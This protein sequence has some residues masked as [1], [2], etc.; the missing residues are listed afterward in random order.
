MAKLRTVIWYTIVLIVFFALYHV[1]S[2]Y[3]IVIVDDGFTY[4]VPTIK[5]RSTHIIDRRRSRVLA[6]ERDALVVFKVIDAGKVK[7]MFG[8][9][10]AVPGMTVLVEGGRVLVDRKDVGPAPKGLDVVATG[11]IV[12]RD[13][14]FMGFDSVR[15]PKLPLAARLI[16]YRDIIGLVTNP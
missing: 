14:V 16:P 13:T 10:V 7:R 1:G 8:R 2:T 3:T 5:P 15:A 12:P 9:A 11:L 4:M 6:L